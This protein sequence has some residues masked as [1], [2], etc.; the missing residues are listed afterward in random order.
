MVILFWG[1]TQHDNPTVN[2]FR[3]SN[4]VQLV[5]SH[6]DEEKAEPEAFD[7]NELDSTI[8]EIEGFIS[9]IDSKF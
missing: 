1:V 7:M 6:A 3:E 4:S 5:N 2:E 9:D 8:L